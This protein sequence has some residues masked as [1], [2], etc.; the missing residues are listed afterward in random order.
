MGHALLPQRG[1]ELGNVTEVL[2]RLTGVREQVFDRHEA[3][4]GDAARASEL[5]DEVAVVAHP[6]GFRQ[7]DTAG[8][9]A[10]HAR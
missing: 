5:L 7:A 8:A 4:D 2:A 6:Q 10:R 3:A 9:G 1:D